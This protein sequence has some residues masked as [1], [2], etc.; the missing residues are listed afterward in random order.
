MPQAIR[1]WRKI[2]HHRLRGRAGTG[3]QSARSGPW[4]SWAKSGGETRRNPG[5]NTGAVGRLPVKLGLPDEKAAAASAGGRIAVTVRYAASCVAG[6]FLASHRGAGYP[7]AIGGLFL[8]RRN[9]LKVAAG[10][11]AIPSV[12]SSAARRSDGVIAGLENGA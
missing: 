12:K 4:R 5:Q 10:G 3:G 8:M 7:G 6:F 11:S 9:R 2:A 1:R